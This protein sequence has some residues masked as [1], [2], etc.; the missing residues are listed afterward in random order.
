[1]KKVELPFPR[2]W[3]LVGFSSALPSGQIQAVE[4][5]DPPILIARDQDGQLSAMDR[6]CP[7]LG[8]DLVRAT[9]KDDCVACPLHGWIFGPDGVSAATPGYSGVTRRL[10][11]YPVFERYG[12]IF[13]SLMS[14]ARSGQETRPAFVDA[15]DEA[16]VSQPGGEIIVDCP[17]HVI[18]C[19]GFDIRHFETI[20]RRG[21]YSEPKISTTSSGALQIEIQ[22]RVLGDGP[23]DRR[24]RRLSRDSIR[25]RI[26]NHGGA[27]LTVESDLGRIQTHLIL[28]LFPVE[29][30]KTLVRYLFAIPRSKTPIVGPALDRLRYAYAFRHADRFL[31]DDT[32]SLAGMRLQPALLAREDAHLKQFFTWLGSNEERTVP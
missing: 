5:T 10:H 2:G 29:G 31:R 14:E 17:W 24:I 30:G 21:F 25:V 18:A 4:H 16:L 3:H 9:I 27:L 12:G 32:L 15:L 26:V 7:H 20:H 28:S 13:V 11:R 6:H 19:N 23:R 8:A 1:M 22:A